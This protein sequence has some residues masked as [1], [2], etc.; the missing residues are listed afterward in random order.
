MK[1]FLAFPL[2][3]FIAVLNFQNNLVAGKNSENMMKEEWNLRYANVKLNFPPPIEVGYPEPGKRITVF[4]DDYP[5]APYVLFLPYNYHE[6]RKLPVIM[7]SLCIFLTT[8]DAVLGYGLSKGMNCIWVT[9]PYVDDEGKLSS[10]NYPECTVKYWL[11]VLEDLNN[12]FAI[13]NS[14]IVIAGFSLGAMTTSYIGNWNN[15]ISSKW[16]GY[17][18]Y[19]HFDDCCFQQQGNFNE[20]ILRIKD[21]KVFLVAG[22]KDSARRCSIK[23]YYK[24]IQ[25]GILVDYMEVPDAIHCPYWILEDSKYT[26]NARQWL[27]SIISD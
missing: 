20:R 3:F 14:K 9:V 11:A 25:K 21:R 22:G 24:L 19:A 17:F 8:E 26:E 7:E 27:N 15:E 12:K 16:S 6:G 1:M 5:E 4:I 13:D 2:F 23:S 18:A 10:W